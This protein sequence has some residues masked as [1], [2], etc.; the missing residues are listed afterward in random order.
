MKSSLTYRDAEHEG[1]ASAL[2]NRIET[3]GLTIA[4]FRRRAGFSRNI[5]YAIS[6]GREMT[7][8]ERKRADKALEGGKAPN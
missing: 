7:P 2:R 3:A 1:R 5:A 6:K 4:E 8:D